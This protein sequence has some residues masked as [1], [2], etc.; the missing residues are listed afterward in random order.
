MILLFQPLASSAF[1]NEVT[2]LD[3]D[4]IPVIPMLDQNSALFSFKTH[5]I[6]ML[7][8]A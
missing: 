4:C 7:K 3:T 6:V 1:G 8:L 5:Y 2:V